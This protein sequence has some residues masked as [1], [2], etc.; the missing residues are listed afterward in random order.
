MDLSIA[1]GIKMRLEEK[2]KDLKAKELNKKRMQEKQLSKEKEKNRIAREKDRLKR[3]REKQEAKAEKERRKNELMW[4]KALEARYP[5]EDTLLDSEPSMTSKPLPNR[6]E[7]SCRLPLRDDTISTIETLNQDA[8]KLLMAWDFLHVFSKMMSQSPVN[9]EDLCRALSCK[10]QTLPIVSETFMSLLRIFVKD[11]SS[12]S[13]ESEEKNNQHCEKDEM[14]E[15]EKWAHDQKCFHINLPHL[16]H[17]TSETWPEVLRAFL[18]MRISSGKIIDEDEV[19]SI[20]DVVRA[21]KV[22]P[23]HE[24]KIS[25]KINALHALVIACYDT[26]RV[27]NTIREHCVKRQKI[28]A[29]KRRLEAEEKKKR[30]EAAAASKREKEKLKKAKEEKAKILQEKQKDSMKKWLSKDQ[31]NGKEEEEETKKESTKKKKKEQ[32]GPEMTEDGFEIVKFSSLSIP[33]VTI[34]EVEEDTDSED[35]EEDDRAEILEDL[36]G[37]GEFGLSR[38]DKLQLRRNKLKKTEERRLRREKR[39]KRRDARKEQ[40]EAR[41][42]VVKQRRAVR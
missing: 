2:E 19:K 28:Y 13:A 18:V 10:I 22:E 21:L 3:L 35:S 34:E 12:Q 8:G 30:K 9:L 4:R 15:L 40:I 39:Q 42:N 7:A 27:S 17:I 32:E 20:K 33:M 26:S 6:P 24:I 41:D 1:D 14:D 5:I 25:H 16:H 37:D 11:S 36:I 23:F 29:E 38:Q 31:E